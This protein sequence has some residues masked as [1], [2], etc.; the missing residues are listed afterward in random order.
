[1]KTLA[2]VFSLN[3]LVAFS[4]VVEEKTTPI[5]ENAPVADHTHNLTPQNN[6]KEKHQQL[7]KGTNIGVIDEP[8]PPPS[9][10]KTFDHGQFRKGEVRF[11]DSE[12]DDDLKAFFREHWS[13]NDE[14]GEDEEWD[15]TI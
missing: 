12:Q 1:M 11:D 2:F 13:G 9:P 4:Q 5:I 14:N 6:N 7:L 8:I 15:W 10:H 3:S